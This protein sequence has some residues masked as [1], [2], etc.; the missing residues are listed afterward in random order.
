VIAH[1]ARHD[2][3]AELI[4][5]GPPPKKESKLL[6]TGSGDVATTSSS[7]NNNNNS[8]TTDESAK[9]DKGSPALPRVEDEDKINAKPTNEASI[10]Q[11]RSGGL[12]QILKQ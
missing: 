3:I 6:V 7:S 1:E 2:E 12:S 8:S 10:S 9:N 5:K 11:I 4:K